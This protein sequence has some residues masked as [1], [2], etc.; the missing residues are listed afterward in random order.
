MTNFLK[1]VAINFPLFGVTAILIAFLLNRLYCLL[2]D[3][4]FYCSNKFDF[5]KS[6]GRESFYGSRMF[7]S[8][9]KRHSNVSR[10]LLVYPIS[11]G[12]SVYF[13][14]QTLDEI[15]FLLAK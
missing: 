4:L 6:S 3:L 15:Y 9:P 13:L 12:L 11:I 14:T 2:A 1:I 8:R 5:S 7:G 10:V